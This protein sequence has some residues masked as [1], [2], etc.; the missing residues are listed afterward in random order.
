MPLASEATEISKKISLI[1]ENWKGMGL[2]S[3]KTWGLSGRHESECI[4]D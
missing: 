3:P 2:S 1:R 4:K